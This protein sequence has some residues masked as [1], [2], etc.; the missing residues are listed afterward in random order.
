MT[1]GSNDE[2]SLLL[3]PPIPTLIPVNDRP[4]LGAL[5]HRTSVRTDHLRLRCARSIVPC[6]RRLTCALLSCG[7]L[8]CYMLEA[9]ASSSYESFYPRKPDNQ[10][11]WGLATF[12]TSSVFLAS[13]PDMSNKQAFYLTP[14]GSLDIFHVLS[15][16]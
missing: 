10:K 16:F 1:G 9:C 11:Y 3:R 12:T 6:R 5:C 15:V 13:E 7:H 8:A 14:P 4:N 2:R